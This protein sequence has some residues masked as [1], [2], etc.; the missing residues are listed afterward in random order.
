MKKEI[1]IEI[2]YWVNQELEIKNPQSI[3]YFITQANNK[4][5]TT[6]QVHNFII[7]ALIQ[8]RYYEPYSGKIAKVPHPFIKRRVTA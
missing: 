8:G 5:F 6:R 4:G 1:A 3:E 7:S 2:E